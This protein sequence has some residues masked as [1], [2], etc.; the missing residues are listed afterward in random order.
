MLEEKIF[1]LELAD[2]DY[3]SFSEDRLTQIFSASFNNSK[4]FRK[5]FLNLIGVGTRQDLR[6]ETQK[7]YGDSKLDVLIL[8]ENKPYIVIENKVDSTVYASQLRKYNSIKAVKNAKKV[9]I[10][11]HLPDRKIPKQ[12]KVIHWVDLY[13]ELSKLLE[14]RD[15]PEIDKFICSNFASYL[16]EMGMY[17]PPKISK[18]DFYEMCE[19][20]KRIRKDGQFELSINKVAIESLLTFVLYIQEI[21]KIVFKEKEYNDIKKKIA[22]GRCPTRQYIRINYLDDEANNKHFNIFIGSQFINLK[23]F[24][25]DIWW[26]GAGVFIDLKGGSCIKAFAGKDYGWSVEYSKEDNF[27]VRE[28]I[29]FEEF[30][31]FVI[32]SWR[33]Y[34]YLTR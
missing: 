16:K 34:L 31:E 27:E 6:S 33:K 32:K 10:V 24:N 11:K 12:W 22:R 2:K 5:I 9:L 18:K 13:M 25:K 29:Y 20:I 23:N 28:A 3:P 17:I 4:E 15:L 7:Q 30:K 19:F 8:K 1:V 14:N 26:I 21:T